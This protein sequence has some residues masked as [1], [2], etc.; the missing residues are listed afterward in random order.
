MKF[1]YDITNYRDLK[2]FAQLINHPVKV[3]PTEFYKEWLPYFSTSKP[4]TYATLT[5]MAK[6]LTVLTEKDI[7]ALIAKE[8]LNFYTL[9]NYFYSQY[10]EKIVYHDENYLMTLPEAIERG[11]EKYLVGEIQVN[12]LAELIETCDLDVMANYQTK[13]LDNLSQTI[14]QAIEQCYVRTDGRNSLPI[15]LERFHYATRYEMNDIMPIYIEVLNNGYNVNFITFLKDVLKQSTFFFDK[16]TVMLMTDQ[17]TLNDLKEKAYRTTYPQ[18][19]A[20]AAMRN[21]TEEDEQSIRPYHTKELFS[22]Y[23]DSLHKGLRVSFKTY[24]EAMTNGDINRMDAEMIYIE[25]KG[26][27]ND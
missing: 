2:K 16:D 20:I 25:T 8:L 27:E 17:F 21:R 5:E 23:I 10:K 18:R 13:I 9:D 6:Q 24:A 15:F 1:S 19:N 14:Y 3:Y 7:K 12:S 22:D 26:N 11:T 4:V